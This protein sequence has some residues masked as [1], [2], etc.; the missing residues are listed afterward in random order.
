VDDALRVR[1]VFGTTSL[2]W[3]SIARVDARADHLRVTSDEGTTQAV[4]ADLTP[5]Q[6]A[7][8]E[9]TVAR[10][11]REASEARIERPAA[12]EGPPK[13]EPP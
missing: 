7:A 1:T 5:D 13:P 6:R 3:A 11:L 12:G 4:G 10:R 8:F 9:R 2:P